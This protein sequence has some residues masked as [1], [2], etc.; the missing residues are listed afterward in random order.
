[1]GGRYSEEAGDGGGPHWTS[2]APHPLPIL[3]LCPQG[4]NIML[5]TTQPA[6]PGPERKS[7][8]IIFREVM[9][10]SHPL[11]SALGSLSLSLVY[12]ST[13]TI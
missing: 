13:I 3:L 4:N 9:S 8:E 7:Y 1:M 5:V 11:L 2:R 6:P 10:A 12:S